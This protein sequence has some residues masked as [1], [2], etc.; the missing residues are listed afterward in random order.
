VQA[1]GL[2]WMPWRETPTGR[3]PAWTA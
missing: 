2:V 3:Q 1:V